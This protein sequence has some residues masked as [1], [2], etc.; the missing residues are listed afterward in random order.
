MCNR[1]L[2]AASY[3]VKVTQVGQQARGPMNQNAQYSNTYNP[4]WRNHPNFSW[5]GNQNIR[6]QANYNHPPQPLQQLEKSMTDMMKKLLLDNQKVMAENQELRTEF[7]NL[8]RQFGQM[9]NNKNIRLV[10]A[11]P[12]DTE[13]NSQVNAVTLRNGRELVEVPKKKKEQSGFEEERVPQP[14][15]VDERNKIES[16]QISERV[17]PPFPQRLRKKNDDYMFHKFLDMLKQIHLNIALVDMLREVPKYAKYIKDIVANKRRLTEFETDALTEECTSRIQHKLPQKRKDS[18]SF[19]IPV[20]IGEI[21]VGRALCDLGASINLM[22]LSVFKQLGLGA[23]RPTT[24]LLQL[25]DRSYYIL[26]TSCYIVGSLFS[27]QILSSW[28]T[29]LMS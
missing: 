6:P 19:T 28:T 16:E 26:G 24:V 4:N 7:R 23:P 29:R 15:E 2:L 9:A 14:V 25:S 21:D 8:E 11:L 13:K 1:C 5:G 18:G 20:R 12:R 22:P 3:V 27:L 17:S 10:G